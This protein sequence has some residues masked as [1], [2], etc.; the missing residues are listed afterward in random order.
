M[1]IFSITFSTSNPSVILSRK[2]SPKNGSRARKW[3][4]IKLLAS[5]IDLHKDGYFN[6]HSDSSWLCKGLLYTWKLDVRSWRKQA[7]MKRTYLSPFW[8]GKIGNVEKLLHEQSSC[9]LS[10]SFIN[11]KLICIHSGLDFIIFSNVKW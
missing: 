3:N 2:T 4:S 1:L 5:H 7:Y 11:K 6:F 9:W 8:V 10:T